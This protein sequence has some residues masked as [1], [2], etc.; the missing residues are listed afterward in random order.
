VW[1]CRGDASSSVTLGGAVPAWTASSQ[2][3]S[4]VN[5]VTSH[6]MIPVD[7]SAGHDKRQSQGQCQ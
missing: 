3:S 5:P 1:L 4:A 7:Q 6:K 2:T